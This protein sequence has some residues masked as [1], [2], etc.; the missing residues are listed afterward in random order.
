MI[1]PSAGPSRVLMVPKLRHQTFETAISSATGGV[2]N[3]PS[4]SGFSRRCGKKETRLGGVE[5]TFS[6]RA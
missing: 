3:P 4:V 1:D 5:V 6:R 2:A